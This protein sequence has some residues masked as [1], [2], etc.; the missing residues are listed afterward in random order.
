[1]ESLG[2][3][4]ADGGKGAADGTEAAV[5]WCEQVWRRDEGRRWTRQKIHMVERNVND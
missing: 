4:R 5:G 2:L 1:M 3:G